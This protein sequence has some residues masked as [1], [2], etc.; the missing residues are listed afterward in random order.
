MWMY[1]IPIIIGVI[2]ALY[3]EDIDKALN[4]DQKLKKVIQTFCGGIIII[5]MIAA[6]ASVL[7]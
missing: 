7:N 3:S 1:L 2:V 5:C 6:V 4:G